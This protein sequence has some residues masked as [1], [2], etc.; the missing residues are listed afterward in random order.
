[1]SV[2]NTHYED[3]HDCCDNHKCSICC[4]KISY[5]FVYWCDQYTQLCICGPYCQQNKDGL[6]ADLIQVK[7]IMDLQD[8]KLSARDV[9]LIR[10]S[11]QNLEAKVRAEEEKGKQIEQ[12]ALIAFRSVKVSIKRG[13]PA[14]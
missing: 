2:I 11:R 8:L 6:I 13:D 14:T 7:A 3:W 1:M 9:T 5:P 4:G 10:S 12:T